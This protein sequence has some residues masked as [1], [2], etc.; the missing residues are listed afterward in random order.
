MDSSDA[1]FHCSRSALACALATSN[2]CALADSSSVCLH[3]LNWVT[4]EYRLDQPLPDEKLQQSLAAFEVAVSR[5]HEMVRAGQIRIR[6]RLW[7]WH[8]SRLPS[9]DRQTRLARLT[10]WNSG[11]SWVFTTTAESQLVR[12][13]FIALYAR[14][15]SDANMDLQT[16]EAGAVFAAILR[17]L[18][19]E[20]R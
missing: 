11:R 18:S 13:Y 9:L 1:C 14:D 5:G 12:I 4:T 15:I 19:I 10:P 3:S 2:A 17:R 20:L 8:E 16:R 6:D 7:I